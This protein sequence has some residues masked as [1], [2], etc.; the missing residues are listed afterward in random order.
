MSYLQCHHNQMLLR[1][2]V[3][4]SYFLFHVP[5]VIFQCQVSNVIIIE[6]CSGFLS[7]GHIHSVALAVL[8]VVIFTVSYFQCRIPNVIIIECCPG[9]LS[10]G[11]IYSVIY[12]VS[13]IQCHNNRMLLWLSVWRSYLQ[14]HISNVMFPM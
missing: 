5:N 13:Y 2:F 10:G 11:H 14:C 3:W 1:L 12:T 7:G 8:L 9:C 6:C 4:R